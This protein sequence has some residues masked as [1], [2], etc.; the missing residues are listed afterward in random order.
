MVRVGS[1]DIKSAAAVSVADF[2]GPVSKVKTRGD[3]LHA[4]D[5]SS[6]DIVV[7]VVQFDF[8]IDRMA[9]V[10]LLGVASVNP[11]RV[12]C[13]VFKVVGDAFANA[14]TSRQENDEHKD[15]P[16]H[17]QLGEQGAQWVCAQ[18]GPHFLQGIY[19]VHGAAGAMEFWATLVSGITLPSRSR[20]VRWVMAAISD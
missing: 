3:A 14:I 9:I 7:I 1:P 18:C 17:T 19:K 16:G 4:S 6:D 5:V 10:R 11:K 15:T 20:T 8:A 13:V 12:H 2:H